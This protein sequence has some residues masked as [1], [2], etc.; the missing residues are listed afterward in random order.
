[1]LVNQRPECRFS[2]HLFVFFVL[3]ACCF[4]YSLVLYF[5]IFHL[6]CYGDGSF[7]KGAQ[8]FACHGFVQTSSIGERIVLS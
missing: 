7:S 3:C 6:V 2:I 8:I 5:S 4:A 1:M